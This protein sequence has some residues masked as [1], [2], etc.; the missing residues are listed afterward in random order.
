[1]KEHI[2]VSIV[3]PCRNE[4]KFIG[5][6]LDSITANDFPK[7]RLE[8]LVVDG[9]S[10]D[11]TREIIRDYMKKNS[12]IRIIDNPKKIVPCAL[13]I[14]I[15]S[16][17]G[18]IIIRMDSHAT[19]ENNYISKC[20]KYLHE[21][22]ADN[23]GGIMITIPR[24]NTFIGKAITTALSHRFGVGNSH[25]RIGSKEPRWVDDVFG[26]C[27]RREVFEKLGF[28]NENLICTQD[29]EFNRRLSNANGKIILVPEIISYYYAR[30]DIKS[31]SKHNFRNGVWAI[32]PFKYSDVMPVSWR[33][34][35]PLVFVASLISS[36][37]LS[38]FFSIF[39]WLFL[40]ISGSYVLTNFY[41]SYL[42]ASK[43]KSTGYFF[44][45]PV[46]FASL[47]IVYGLGSI[48]GLMK[49]ITFRRFWKNLFSLRHINLLQRPVRI[50]KA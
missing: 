43:E 32:L 16:A 10:E 25:Y 9:A 38:F 11:G 8:I 36:F 30:S 14:G 21:Y 24:D 20:I 5:R 12:F 13:N 40:F 4:A 47:H 44:V 6:C 50:K 3:M 31:F 49:V 22:K 34:L 19:Y 17:S 29:I 2:Y 18:E 37:I 46:I 15:K 28:F 1:M 39:I 42:I 33:H 7:D 35:V 23:V 41:Y 26:G 27:Y 48:W 45:M